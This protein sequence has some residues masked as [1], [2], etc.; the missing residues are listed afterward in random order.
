MFYVIQEN[1]FRESHYNLL[2]ET[3][4][5]LKLPYKVVRVFP[6]IDKIVDIEDIPDYDYEVKKLPDLVVP[7]EKIFVF[8]AVKLARICR[9]KNWYPGSLLNDNHDFMIY[10]KYYKDNLLNYDSEILKVSDDI[11]WDIDLKFIRPSKDS[12]AFNGK[13]YNKESWKQVIDTNI[14]NQRGILTEDT[15]I[16]VSSPK[17]IYKEIRFWVIGGKIIT[18]SQYK[19][20]Y[21]IQY[22]TYYEPEALEYAQKM[23]DIYQVS[24]AFVIDVCLCDDGWKIVEINCINCAGFYL[25]NMQ[26][27]IMELEYYFNPEKFRLND[28]SIDGPLCG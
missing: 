3:L 20:G 7:N 17:N 9:D 12:K 1:I 28:M 11:D 8:G 27:M 13:L 14:N 15:L 22:N 4:D 6:Y 24:E 26:K 10:S 19:I 25:C 16:Q 2:I 21:T 5:K 18:G 23:V